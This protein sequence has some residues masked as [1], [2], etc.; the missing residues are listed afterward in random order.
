MKRALLFCFLPIMLMGC[1]KKE[2]SKLRM[3]VGTYTNSD[4]KGVYSYSVSEDFSEFKLLDT[5]RIDNP[6]YLTLSEDGSRIYA[7]SE[8]SDSSASV[9]AIAFDASNGKFKVLNNQMT[10]GTDPCYVSTNGSVVV[11]A[12][13]GG[14]LSVFPIQPDGSLKPMSQF[15]EGSIGGPDTLRQI[16]PHV[17]CVAFSRDN[18]KLW[19]SDFSADR[20]IA[21]DIVGEG[22]SIIPVVADDGEHW[23]VVVGEDDGPR[24]IVFSNDGKFAYSI[25]E[26]SGAVTVYDVNDGLLSVIQRIQ[27]D[28]HNARA[29][30]DIKISKDGSTLYASVRR[31]N[32]G[33][34]VF[35]IDEST[36]L[37]SKLDYT[38]TGEHPRNFNISP[39]GKYLLCACRDSDV[40]EV[41][42]IEQNGNMKGTLKSTGIKLNVP[43]PVCIVFTED[44]E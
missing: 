18:S 22:D 19:V 15:F 17:H 25:G 27:A 43:R 3:V 9:Y 10:E 5:C 21:F 7:V 31:K 4:S 2:E 6:S 44:G 36:G 33:I 29:S 42:E 39:D 14:S 16:K 30:A 11:T 40:I 28:E 35:R 23:A 20:L 32:D 26:L 12:N 37:L 13:Y 34:A 38:M 1:M 24:H 8:M 41:F